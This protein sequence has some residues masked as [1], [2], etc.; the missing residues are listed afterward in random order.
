MNYG[1]FSSE[2]LTKYKDTSHKTKKLNCYTCGLSED[3]LTPKMQVQGRG[4][5]KILIVSQSVSKQMDKKGTVYTGQSTNYLKK[6]LKKYNI[7]IERD[8]WKTN[9]VQCYT[10]EVKTKHIKCCQK[11]VIAE[12]I[13]KK[14]NIII[15]LGK[16]SVESVIGKYWKKDLGALMRWVNWYVPDRNYNAWLCPMI[17]P[18]MIYNSKNEK[19]V[20]LNIN[21]N[22]NKI[23]KLVN[24]PIPEFEEE[25]NQIEI[26]TDYY[27]IKEM[28]AD[29]KK[30]RVAA[31]DY[32]TTGLKPHAEN[33]KIVCCSIA[34]AK[35]KSYSFMITNRVT[36]L[37]KEFLE[38]DRI[39]KIAQNIKFEHNWSHHMFK[40]EVQG[41]I[42][43]TMLAQHTFDS[44]RAITS[45]KF[46][47]YIYYG[48]SDYDSEIAP[49]LR[50]VDGT[51]NGINRIDEISKKDLLL[52]CGIDSLIEHKLAI[53]QMKLFGVIDP[54]SYGKTLYRKK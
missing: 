53:M 47:S 18:S 20:K 43:D 4:L 45:L 6:E 15:L 52:Y 40:T 17:H 22:I 3:C 44:R 12:I 1:F 36:S 26:L 11:R 34:P 2:A 5:K 24:T 19:S 29:L 16:T 54:L 46:Q 14:P 9:A 41:W 10:D 33:H 7:D 51:A 50:S 38:N 39:Y 27:D 42:W 13:E 31:F 37:L 49:L 8:C 25:E 30:T 23:V 48:I 32:E 35:D 21:K 28:F